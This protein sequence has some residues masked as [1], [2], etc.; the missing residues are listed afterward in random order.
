MEIVVGERVQ[1]NYRT[2]KNHFVLF[3]S[4]ILFF[5]VLTMH[6]H[7]PATNQIRNTKQMY[8]NRF[9]EFERKYPMYL[10]KIYI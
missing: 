1:K 7:T 9:K 8:S 4:S 10:D 6:I 5:L 3:I 2:K